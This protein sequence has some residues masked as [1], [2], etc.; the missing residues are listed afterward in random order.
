MAMLGRLP[1][2]REALE[3]PFL[4][5]GEFPRRLDADAKLDQMQRLGPLQVMN[6][7]DFGLARHS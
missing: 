3:V 7:R 5:L 2:S 4:P 6:K 1:G